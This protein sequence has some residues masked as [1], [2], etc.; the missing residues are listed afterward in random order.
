MEHSFHPHPVIAA[1]KIFLYLLALTALLFMGR[2]FLGDLFLQL[3]AVGW[4]AGIASV[5]L[6]FLMAKFQT[7]TLGANTITYSHGIIATKR[8]ILPYARITETSYTQGPLERI[9]GVG[10]ITIDTAGGSEIAIHVGNV[11]YSDIRALL[12][13]I[14]EKTGK[15]GGF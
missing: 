11:R 4:L 15:G 3:L 8:V 13:E 2:D 9:L 5:F 1:V 6:A 14:G 12:Q 10:T 7:M